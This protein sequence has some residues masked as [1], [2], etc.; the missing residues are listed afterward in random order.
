MIIHRDYN[1]EFDDTGDEC[2]S[3]PVT[4]RQLDLIGR[5]M[6]RHQLDDIEIM[7]IL[8]DEDIRILT[9]DEE[10]MDLTKSEAGRLIG[11]LLEEY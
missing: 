6:D 9:N 11:C 10:L 5:L 3:D 4:S 8:E 1:P 7:A 2:V